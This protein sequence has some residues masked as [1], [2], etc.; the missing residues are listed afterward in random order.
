MQDKVTAMVTQPRKQIPRQRASKARRV[1]VREWR[2]FM[3][4]KAIDCAIALDI[5]RESYLRLERTPQKFNNGE[6][7][8]LADIIGVNPN[9][10]WFPPPVPGQERVSLDDLIEDMPEPMQRAAILAVRGIAGK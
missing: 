1:Y 10:F 5:E 3:G 9:Q 2:R 8:V 6:M 7:A 4:V